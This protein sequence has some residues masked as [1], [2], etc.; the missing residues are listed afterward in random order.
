MGYPR[1]G[2]RSIGEDFADSG[3]PK[4]TAQHF[5]IVHRMR[6]PRLDPEGYQ[7]EIDTKDAVFYRTLAAQKKAAGLN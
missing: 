6:S 5:E 3:L 7:I 2:L 4:L 1:Y